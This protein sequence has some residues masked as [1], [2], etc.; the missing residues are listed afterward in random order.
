MNYGMSSEYVRLW[1][2]H[3]TISHTTMSSVYV[4]EV[5]PGKLTVCY[6]KNHH[7]E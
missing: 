3:T 2:S 6:R 5:S 7:F 4:N 1:N